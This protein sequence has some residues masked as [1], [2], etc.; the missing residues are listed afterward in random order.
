MEHATQSTRGRPPVVDL[1][2]WRSAR[3]ELRVRE[4][5][6][7]RRSLSRPRRGVCAPQLGIR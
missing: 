5:A 4:Q 1:P 6:Q 7:G 3:A 2:T